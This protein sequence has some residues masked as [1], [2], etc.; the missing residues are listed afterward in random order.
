MSSSSRSPSPI[1]VLSSKQPKKSAGQRDKAKEKKK[2]KHVQIVDPHG[3]N[4][5]PDKDAYKPPEG[6]VLMQHKVE[7]SDFDWDVV[8]DDDNL[9]LWLVRVPDGVS[10]TS[11]IV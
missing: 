5:A 10:P 8:R 9:E 7:H 6:A 3:R 1:P 2:S 4:E 11:C